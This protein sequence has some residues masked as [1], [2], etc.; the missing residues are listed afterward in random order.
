ML[1]LAA[2][3][4]NEIREHGAK[5]YP[6]RMLR[7]DDGDGWRAGGKFV[8]LFPLINRR[9]DS[10]RNRFS[11]APEDFRAAEHAATERGLDRWDGIILIPIT[12]RARASSIG[13]MPGR[14]TAM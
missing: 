3:L 8:R 7:R 12:R 11:I 1:F 5:D 13:S 2:N 6:P 14:G 4:E 10:P 9:D